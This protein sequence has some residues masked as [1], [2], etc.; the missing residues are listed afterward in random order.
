MYLPE[1][2][3]FVAFAHAVVAQKACSNSLSPA[4]GPPVV[5]KGYTARVFANGLTKPRGITF[6]TEGNMLVV[7][8]GKGI[9]ALKLKDE[10]GDCVGVAQQIPVVSNSAV[11]NCNDV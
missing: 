4:N 6:D 1:I 9:T 3:A 11:R 10:G 2:A 7:E 8:S 5:A